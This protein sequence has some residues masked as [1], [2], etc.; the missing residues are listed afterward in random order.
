MLF[1]TF[2]LGNDRY[3]VE[4]NRVLEVLPLLVLKRLPQAPKGVAGLFNLRGRPVPA[5]DLNELSFGQP[6]QERLSTRIILVHY[7]D[8]NGRN[9]PL[10]LIAEF[11]T[12]TLRKEPKDFVDTGITVAQAPYLGPVLMDAQGPIQWLHTQ[13]LV[14]EPFRELLF[15]Q[16]PAGLSLT[17]CRQV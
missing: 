11:V 4:A 7:T 6:A 3:A 10:G 1:L 9:H 2:Q 16:A 8:A 12:Q 14:S 13:H 5:I 17:A 15:P